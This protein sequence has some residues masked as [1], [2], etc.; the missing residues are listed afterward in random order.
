M[1][2]K[3]TSEVP[4]KL[5]RS[6]RRSNTERFFLSE[7]IYAYAI[8]VTDVKMQKG[9]FSAI[10]V[11]TNSTDPD[12]VQTITALAKKNPELK[13]TV[14]TVDSLEDRMELSQ[15]HRKVRQR[16]FELLTNAKMRD[17]QRKAKESL[18]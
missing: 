6:N 14:I 17:A 7:D 13:D 1:Y 10:T 9:Q 16:A 3:Y 11:V 18:D 2:D 15:R 5:H 12:I 4:E 8:F